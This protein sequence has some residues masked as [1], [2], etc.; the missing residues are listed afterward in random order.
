MLAVLD[1]PGT[2]LL[3]FD[4]IA[5]SPPLLFFQLSFAMIDQPL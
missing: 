2:P 4:P 3:Q 1:D 5:K